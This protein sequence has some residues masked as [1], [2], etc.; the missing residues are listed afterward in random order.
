MTVKTLTGEDAAQWQKWVDGVCLLAW[1]HGQNPKWD[2]LHWETRKVGG[3]EAVSEI[4]M[5]EVG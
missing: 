4:G 5:I 2:N 3:T 1:S